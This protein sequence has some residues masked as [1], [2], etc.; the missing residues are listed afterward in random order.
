MAAN[1]PAEAETVPATV[2]PACPW[3]VIDGLVPLL[4][5]DEEDAVPQPAAKPATTAN[6]AART[7]CF[8]PRPIPEHL[9]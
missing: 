2:L 8:R 3:V 6:A 7:D 1:G 9:P 5:G 4:D